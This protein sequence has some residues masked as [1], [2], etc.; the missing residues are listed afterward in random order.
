LMLQVAEN[1]YTYVGSF[2]YGKLAPAVQ[3]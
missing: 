3:K 1:R 2:L